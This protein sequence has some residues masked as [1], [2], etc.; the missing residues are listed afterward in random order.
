[1][2]AVF[3][4]SNWPVVML[5]SGAKMS[6]NIYQKLNIDTIRDKQYVISEIVRARMKDR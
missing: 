1:M 3:Q 4:A 5:D 2:C 6:I